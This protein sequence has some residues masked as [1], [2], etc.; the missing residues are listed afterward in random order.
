MAVELGMTVGMLTENLTWSE[1]KDW[2]MFYEMKNEVEE[3]MDWSKL[4]A[5]EIQA[6]FGG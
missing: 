6:K 2:I 1:Y 3:P 4:S 5:E